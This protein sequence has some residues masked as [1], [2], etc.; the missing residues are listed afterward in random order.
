MEQ[1]NI[2][3]KLLKSLFIFIIVI[4]LSIAISLITDWYFRL[5]VI[6]QSYSSKE[7]IK[8]MIEGEEYDCSRFEELTNNL[9][10]RR[11]W[12]K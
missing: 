1:D 11:E 8:I 10:Y 7:C 5:P 2:L 3:I 6:H 4:G 9:K 12:V